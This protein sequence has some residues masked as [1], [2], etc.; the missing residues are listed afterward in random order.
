MLPNKLGRAVLGTDTLPLYS[1][2]LP[3]GGG[4]RTRA[5][6]ALAPRAVYFPACVQ[7][8]FGPATE[9]TPGV[10]GSFEQLCER[11]GITLFVPSG[12][13]GL[14]CGTPWSS[15]GLAAG[16]ATMLAE[17][18]AALRTATRNGEL[19]IICDASSCTEGL[20]T[21]I[22][23]DRNVP[24]LRVVDA[25]A[26]AAERILPSLSECRKTDSLALHPTCSSTRMGINDSLLTHAGGVAETVQVPEN[27]GCC[28]F[29]GNRGMLQPELTESAIRA[30]AADVATLDATAFVSCNRT[31]EL[32]LTRATGME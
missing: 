12:I 23:G 17:T 27:W 9:G 32:G 14:C 22:E 3:G 11:A 21:T 24:H 28:G 6:P 18:L 19:A 15:K 10:Q 26:F 25:V 8:M 5:A 20:R 13:D 7:T 4:R 1:S 16:E 30:Q 2:K 31:C 29:A